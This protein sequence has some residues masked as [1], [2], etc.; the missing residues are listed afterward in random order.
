MDRIVTKYQKYHE[1]EAEEKRISGS[2]IFIPASKYLNNGVN[3]F[4]AALSASY[5]GVITPSSKFNIDTMK[6]PVFIRG[7]Q[8][9]KT[10]K[11]IRLLMQKERDFYFI[12]SGYFGNEH[13]PYKRWHRVTKNDF[14]S[15]VI[16]K[17]DS[18][19]A[20]TL[21]LRP[22]KWNKS[23][24]NI[25]ICPPSM[26]SMGFFMGKKIKEED[27]D[28]W[29]DMVYK[30]IR[31]YTDRPIKIRKKPRDRKDRVYKD[32]IKKHF[33]GCYALITYNS[34]AA[35]EAVYNGVPAIT[36]APNAASAVCRSN[37]SD[38]NSLIYP[39]RT[40]WVNHLSYCQFSQQEAAS[41]LARDI[42]EGER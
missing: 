18:K 36:L 39:D 6:G 28:E 8:G 42:L 22:R 21:A 1:D 34:I 5:D 10:H 2:P 27:V 17:R 41:G 38:I 35:V 4:F 31:E 29:V 24:E 13:L 40:D 3:T 26:K 25:L 16:T 15:S 33:K 32:P 37:I 20:R 23:G 11:I 19:R 7:F 14:Q 9:S 30:E 12:D